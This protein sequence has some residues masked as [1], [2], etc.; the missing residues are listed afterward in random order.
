MP[1]SHLDEKGVRE[2]AAIQRDVRALEARV[3]AIESDE[4]RPY[5]R[6]F[7]EDFGHDR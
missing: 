2:V 6:N 3:F 1:G 5:G 4:S 7:S